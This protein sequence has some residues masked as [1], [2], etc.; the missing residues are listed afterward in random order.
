MIIDALDTKC[1]IKLFPN[2]TSNDITISL[3]GID[4]VNISIIDSQG[5][6]LLKES[7]VFDKDNISLSNYQSGIYFVNIMT[8]DESKQLRVIKL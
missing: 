1:E 7:G 8:S 2:P 4:Y 3:K 5:K 6:I